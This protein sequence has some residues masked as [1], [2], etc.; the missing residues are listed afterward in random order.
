MPARSVAP[1][2]ISTSGESETPKVVEVDSAQGAKSLALLAK[3]ISLGNLF[4][5]KVVL[6]EAMAIVERERREKDDGE[7][8]AK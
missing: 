1:R 3:R 8:K 2:G 4:N 5:A 6:W 7:T